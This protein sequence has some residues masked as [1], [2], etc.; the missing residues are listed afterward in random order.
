MKQIIYSQSTDHRLNS[1]ILFI[2]VTTL[3]QFNC[4]YCNTKN[5]EKHKCRHLDINKL[6]EFVNMYDD[7]TYT[8]QWIKPKLQILQ[9]FINT[10]HN[11]IDND[12]YDVVLSGGEPTYNNNIIDIVNI[13]AHSEKIKVISILTN[14]QADINVY[15]N[16]GT[17]CNNYNRFLSLLFSYHFN[18]INNPKRFLDNLNVLHE[19]NINC[20]LR[21]IV[22]PLNVTSQVKSDIDYFIN[23]DRYNLLK[24][25]LYV[26]GH[27]FCND[28]YIDRIKKQLDD[29]VAGR[30]IKVTYN[31]GSTEILS[32]GYIQS[33]NYNPFKGMYCESIYKRHGLT[34]DYDLYPRCYSSDQIRLLPRFRKCFSE[35]M[36]RDYISFVKSTYLKCEL[37]KC[38]CRAGIIGKKCRQVS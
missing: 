8:P 12:Y 28:D 25:I 2:F 27:G 1:R 20:E 7:I 6:Q 32:T 31:D 17:I 21:L 5:V 35:S 36:V 22:D 16:I 19:Y 33:L 26:A 18:S 3:C 13:L 23:N 37:D 30:Y 4:Y 9:K 24:E 38:E 11:R 15:K 34:V 14:G 29:K 10:H